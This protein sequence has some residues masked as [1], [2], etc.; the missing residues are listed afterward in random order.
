MST[1]EI[2]SLKTPSMRLDGLTALVTGAGRGIGAG[3]AI[4]LAEAGA[5]I[6]AVSRTGDELD[7]LAA[8]VHKIGPRARAEVCDVTDDAQLGHLFDGLP[9]L[10]ILVNNA[11]INIPQPFLEVTAE[12]LDYVLT[13]NVRA[14]FR[15][16]QA[17]A[18]KMR[19]GGRGGAIVNVSS[20]V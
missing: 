9:R 2:E 5:D 1:D 12:N 4:A 20:Q 6:I 3:L 13:L 16:A 18:A 17:S 14:A 19:E 7:R 8:R 10:D 11:G 15:V